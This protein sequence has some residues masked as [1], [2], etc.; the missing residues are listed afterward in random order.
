MADPDTVKLIE[1]L[2]PR[3]VDSFQVFMRELR[4]GDLGGRPESIG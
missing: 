4:P 1:P 3:V 2:L